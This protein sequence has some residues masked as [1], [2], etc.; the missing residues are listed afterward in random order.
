MTSSG[1]IWGVSENGEVKPNASSLVAIFKSLR[2]F[3]ERFNLKEIADALQAVRT[4]TE[5]EDVMVVNE[6]NEDVER[7]KFEEWC[8]RRND[9]DRLVTVN[10]DGFICYED[11]SIDYAWQGWL[12]RACEKKTI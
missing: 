9:G 7:E 8:R 12:A 2:L 1:E 4:Q 10:D 6:V 5:K 3:G 11:I